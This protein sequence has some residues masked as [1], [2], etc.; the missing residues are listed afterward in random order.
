MIIW[1]KV[2]WE[3]GKD[4]HVVLLHIVMKSVIVLLVHCRQK[5][6]V[7]WEGMVCCEYVSLVDFSQRIFLSHMMCQH[8][9]VHVLLCT[10][11]QGIMFC[12][13]AHV[14]CNN[15]FMGRWTCA[16][17]IPHMVCGTSPYTVMEL[18]VCL[19]H[20]RREKLLLIRLLWVVL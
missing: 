3:W 2:G 14:V 7:D 13:S 19:Q 17:F 11:R 16:V 1:R 8:Y 4:C 6:A 15:S 5:V 10:C 20:L 9:S 18:L 12:T